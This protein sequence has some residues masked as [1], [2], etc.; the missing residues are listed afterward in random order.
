MQQ[1]LTSAQHLSEAKR[2]LADDYKPDK[3]SQKASQEVLAAARWHLK[4][5]GAT[6]RRPLFKRRGASPDE[7]PP[8][9]GR[10]YCPNLFTY[11]SEERNALTISA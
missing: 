10:S 11:S 9:R 6:A 5:I 2:A 3:D 1:R 7:S 4:A 8:L